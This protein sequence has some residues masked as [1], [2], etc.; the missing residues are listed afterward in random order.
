VEIKN[1]TLVTG[2][3]A[4]FPD[5]VTSRGLKHLK[6]LQKQVRFGDRAVMYYLVQRMDAKR[7]SPADHIDP[8]YGKELRKAIKNGVE[9]MVYDV[10]LNSKGIRLNSTLPFEV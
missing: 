3:V 10:M 5:A 4:C 7:F 8:L 1:C 6:E 2:G 9:I